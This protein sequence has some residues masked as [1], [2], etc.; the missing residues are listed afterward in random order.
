MNIFAAA[1]MLCC[2]GAATRLLLCYVSVASYAA[3]VAVAAMRCCM[4]V[5]SPP[6]SPI[7][8]YFAVCRRC[9]AVDAELPSF[10]LSP[11]QLSVY[12]ACF[13]AMLIIFFD[14]DVFNTCQEAFS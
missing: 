7:F 4:R 2:Y 3:V 10:T 13:D 11:L 1:A 6:T 9:Y 14:A 5:L 8:S 12:D